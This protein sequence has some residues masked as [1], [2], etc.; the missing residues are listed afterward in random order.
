MLIAFDLDGTLLPFGGGLSEG[1]LRAL[2]AAAAAGHILTIASGRSL[3]VIPEEL[4][5]LTCFSYCISSGGAVLSIPATGETL[6]EKDIPRELALRLM[7]SASKHGAAFKISLGEREIYELKWLW[8]VMRGIRKMGGAVS[9]WRFIAFLNRRSKNGE[10]GRGKHF[11]VFSSSIG[12]QAAK[13]REPI[14]KIECVYK[15]EES[16]KK[17]QTMFE[18]SGE[19]E[20]IITSERNMEITVKG[21]DKGAALTALAKG[22]EIPKE[23]ILAFGDSNNDLPM[24]VAAGTLVVMENSGEA[25]LKAVADY[26]APPAEKDGAAQMLN[27]L[28]GL[29]GG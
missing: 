14:Y 25:A 10:A 22:L 3:P 28:L 24:R 19:L 9:P 27:K 26:I 15:T 11:F 21:A 8:H 6:W 23:R 5:K 4:L 12:R 17:Q 7:K 2:E 29:S 13:A 18:R 20:A 16:C 1:N